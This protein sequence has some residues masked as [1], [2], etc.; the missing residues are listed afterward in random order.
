M[1]KSYDMEAFLKDIQSWG[2]TLGGAS[3]LL[4]AVLCIYLSSVWTYNIFFH[5]LTGFPGPK[6]AAATRLYEF[7]YDVIRRGKY[8][9]KIE[10]MHKKYGMRYSSAY[11]YLTPLSSQSCYSNPN[12]QLHESDLL[13]VLLGPIIRISPYEIVIND[14]NFYNEVYVAANTRRTTI[15]PRYRT[16]IGFDGMSIL[17]YMSR[18]PTSSF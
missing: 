16:G 10:E 9:Y 8:I 13:F 18:F 12:W 14:P 11:T 3:T 7:Y 6:L 15:W 4:A 1:Q 5:P 17:H 2:T